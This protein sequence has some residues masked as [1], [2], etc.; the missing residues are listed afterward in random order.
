MFANLKFNFAPFQIYIYIENFMQWSIINSVPSITCI[1]IQSFKLS[2]MFIVTIYYHHETW[3]RYTG[4]IHPHF[5]GRIARKT[6]TQEEA[7]ENDHWA[8]SIVLR[9]GRRYFEIKVESFYLIASTFDNRLI[10]ML[11][12]MLKLLRV[13]IIRRSHVLTHRHGA[14]LT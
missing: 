10:D 12:A 6:Y 2:G 13:V 1:N 14:N 5:E 4:N 8:M 9:V 7:I 3:D 11:C